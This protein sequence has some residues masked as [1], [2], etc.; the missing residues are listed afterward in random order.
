MGRSSNENSQYVVS[1]YMRKNVHTL[2]ESA[3]LGDAV[4]MMVREKTNGMVIVDSQKRVKGIL[5]T[6]DIIHELVP[7]YLEDDRRM[8][9]FESGD[10][11]EARLLAI[12]D[13]PIKKL[14]TKKVVCVKQDHTLME[15]AA[16]LSEFKIRQLPVTDDKVV[17]VGYI[18]RTD[19]KRAMYDILK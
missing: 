9:P 14:M 16:L 5:S 1:K 10:Q 11:F 17:L 6:W 13:T 8:A 4:I 7:D 12:K 19:I 18:N 2:T 15:A 3:T